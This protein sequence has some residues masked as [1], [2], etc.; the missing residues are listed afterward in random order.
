MIRSE[1]IKPLQAALGLRVDGIRGPVTTTAILAAADQGRLALLP[2]NDNAP[3]TA[4]AK[5]PW[6]GDD[7]P[8][9]GR[10]KLQGVNAALQS[11]VL[12]ASARCDVPFTCIEGVRSI[13]RQRALVKAGASR[14]MRSRHLTGHAVDLW[15]LDTVTGKGLPSGT[16]AAEARL[17]ADLRKIAAV[18]KAVA[19]ERGVAV[20]WGGDWSSFPDGP[21][22]QLSWAAFPA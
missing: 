21:H 4:A 5:L 22:F 13:E 2:L 16:P 11:V 3:V 1:A 15:P 7:L 14:T 18:V 17:W 19:A 10:A 12:A 20:E 9:A 6:P 8:E